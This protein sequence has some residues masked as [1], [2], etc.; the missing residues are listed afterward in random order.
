MGEGW[1]EYPLA[2]SN[3]ASIAAS[4]FHTVKMVL[5]GSNIKCYVDDAKIF[6]YIDIEGDENGAPL[7]SGGIGL[8]GMNGGYSCDEV[9]VT[10]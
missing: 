1:T 7:L 9:L 5:A 3:C 8:E 2:T 4:I 10:K 6:D